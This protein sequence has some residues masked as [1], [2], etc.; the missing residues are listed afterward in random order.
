MKCCASLVVVLAAIWLAGQA[1]A[2]PLVESTFDSDAEGWLVIQGVTGPNHFATGGNPG[3]YISG[4]D[5]EGASIWYFHASAADY[6]LRTFP[7][8]YGGAIH[9]DLK[10]LDAGWGQPFSGSGVADVI[11]WS[12]DSSVSGDV[13]IENIGNPGSEWTHYEIPLVETAGWVWAG[14]GL[15]LT[16]EQME[17][18]VTSF[19]GLRIRGE[20]YDQVPDTAALDSVAI[21]PV[22]EPSTALLL[23]LGLVGIAVQRRGLH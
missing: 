7:N 8:A 15:P 11:I 20:F 1:G 14:T 9:F 12:W 16:Q 10:Q 6:S 4:T 23:A 19:G 22:P 5:A 17:K 21:F 13:V 18:V 3:G 2:A